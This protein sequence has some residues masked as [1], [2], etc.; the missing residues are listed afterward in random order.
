MRIGSIR[1][2]ARAFR[3]DA[4]DVHQCELDGFVASLIAAAFIQSN[5]T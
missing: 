3:R 1:S 5:T 4:A 2:S